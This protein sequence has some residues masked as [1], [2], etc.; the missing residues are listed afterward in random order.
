MDINLKKLLLIVL[1][2][3]LG[4]SQNLIPV[5]ETYNDGNIKSI[6]YHK[7]IQN[8][9][10]RVKEEGYYDNGKKSYEGTLKH[11][12][13]DGLITSWYENGQIKYEGTFKDGERD[14]K[15]IEW[16]ENGKNIQFIY[17]NGKKKSEET[18]KN[19]K[20]DGLVTY[21]YENGKKSYEGTFKDGELLLEKLY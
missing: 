7:K 4:Y 18:Y 17:N 20:K 16:E 12:K 9:I 8:G 3:S 13:Q 11:G 14:G 21:W 2:L 19:D 10:E 6:T 5:I 1:L 15:W